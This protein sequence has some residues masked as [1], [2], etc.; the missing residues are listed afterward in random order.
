MEEKKRSLVLQLVFAFV[1]TSIIPIILIN[2][3]SYYNISKTVRDNNFA[4][5]EYSLNRTKNMLD[6]SLE[7]YEDVLFQIYA[8]DQVIELVNKIN[9]QEELEVSRKQLR[10]I[11]S[12]FFYIKD[13]IKDITIITESGTVIF[14]DVIT[15]YSTKSSWLQ[16]LEMSQEELYQ[17]VVDNRET[18][19]LPTR[20][21]NAY[22]DGETYLFHMVHRIVDFNKQNK[23]IG[24]AVISIDEKLLNNICVGE[25]ENL[26]AYNY[27]VDQEGRIVSSSEKKYL[28]TALN[29]TDGDKQKAYYTFAQKQEIFPPKSIE[30]NYITDEKLD[31]D[32][33]NVSNQEEVLGR[34]RKQQR[35]TYTVL[36]IA[37]IILIVLITYLI[38]RLTHS[39][40]TV[41]AIMQ[42]TGEGKLKERVKIDKKMPREVEVIAY[43]YN[44]TMDQLL[45]ALEKEKQL[46]RRRKNAEIVALE[47]QLNPHFLYNTLDTI[48]WVAIRKGDFEIS[49]AINALARI[50]RYG[51]DNSNGIVTI[52]DE[53]EWLKQY[54]L[55]QQ[56]RL[57]EELE[58][59]INIPPEIMEVKVHKLLI[60]PFVENSFVH[61]FEGVRRKHIVKIEMKRKECFLKIL[62]EDNGKG[63]PRQIVESVN[64]GNLYGAEGINQIGLRNAIY[65]IQLY[66][67]NNMKIHVESREGEY[68]RILLSIPVMKEEGEKG[69]ESCGS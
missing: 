8:D 63:M 24:I 2:I 39:I 30:I 32:I 50:L 68:T 66:Y 33:V 41:V 61:G 35:M 18:Y 29:I 36:L 9:N 51:I 49:C 47:A 26:S 60:Q 10:R 56:T 38:R 31:W 28:G 48:N 5:M 22:S 55:L 53:Y 69:Y 57:K 59:Q 20:K 65:R 62:I 45:D 27:I 19:F 46:E 17:M 34:I 16:N 1:I 12:G 4:M 13:Y 25:E 52:R 64:Q 37:I 11:L 43:Q 42:S 6:I 54:F 7:S 21:A 23:E 58:S 14:Y 15:G 67:G 40:K 3:F 44:R